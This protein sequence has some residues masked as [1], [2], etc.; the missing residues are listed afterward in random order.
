MLLTGR[1]LSGREAAAWGLVNA[2]VPAAEL[3]QR[4]AEVVAAVAE[5]APISVRG[6][7]RGIGVVLEK[8]S[9]DRA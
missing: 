6:S 8:L 7:K 9:V 3:R 1:T 4:T 5:S 2:A